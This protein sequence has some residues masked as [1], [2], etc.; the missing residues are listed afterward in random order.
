MS[1]WS[2]CTLGDLGT[3]VGGGTPARETDGYWGGTIPWI[4][5]GELTG[6]SEK[7]VYGTRDC[8]SERG[9]AASG[10][11][12]LPEGSLLVTSRASI[13]SCAMAGTPI[14]TNQGFK[15]IILGSEVDTSFLFYLARTLTREMT[16]R[17][18]G[19]TFLEISGRE[20][21][22][23]EVRMP[24]LAEQ[25]RIAEIL[26]TIDEAIQATERIIAKHETVCSGL[27]ES[28]LCGSI[29][30]TR[31][32]H[33]V[34]D[35]CDAAV[36]TLSMNATDATSGRFAP[37]AQLAEI[38]DHRRIP[39]REEDRPNGSVP[40]FG[41]NGQQGWIDRAL[42]DEPLILLAEDGG[43][44]DE[45]AHRPIA[46]RIN[47]PSWV[48]N[49][50]HVLRASEGVDQSYLFWSLRN[51]D[52]RR[53]IA[54]GTRSKLTRHEM[55]QIPLSV[56]PLAQ[57]QRIAEILDT[58]EETIQTNVTKCEKLKALRTGLAADLLSGRV[59]TVVS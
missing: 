32:S 53:W 36:R 26:D 19:T 9:L 14:A 54:G 2:E 33:A 23:I 12:L 34:S 17:A 30:S 21:G 15:N 7:Y 58:V 49:H 40:Y 48:N 47:G 35:E 11:I 25:R 29:A 1:E 57:Q 52:I 13:G 44:F 6:S 45:F 43:H 5:P 4:T 3:V 27:A 22:S 31:V 59:R 56:P 24:P 8:L 37:L 46:Y 10:A 18:S 38:L 42:F 20:F 50:A 28:L 41:A 16:R 51:K 39:V 55:E